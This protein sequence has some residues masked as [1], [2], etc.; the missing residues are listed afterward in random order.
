M[1]SLNVKSASNASLAEPGA[2][3]VITVGAVSSNLTMGLGFS[4]AVVS[5]DAS[6]GVAYDV[7]RNARDDADGDRSL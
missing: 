6:V 5:G 4:S 1:F 7:H 2:L 3:I